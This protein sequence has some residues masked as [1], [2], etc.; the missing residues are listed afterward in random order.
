MYRANYPAS[1]IGL[2]VAYTS[3]EEPLLILTTEII[4]DWDTIQE[5]QPFTSE[6]FFTVDDV[7]SSTLNMATYSYE[8]TVV[9]AEM[10]T[11]MG[12][13]QVIGMAM[14]TV[15]PEDGVGYSSFVILEDPESFPDPPEA[16]EQVDDP[17]SIELPIGLDNEAI[18]IGDWIEDTLGI[19]LPCSDPEPLCVIAATQAYHAARAQE[20]EAWQNRIALAKLGWLA[21]KGAYHT[22][23]LALR[24]GPRI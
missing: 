14:T 22:A 3:D 8:A 24:G 15:N 20:L 17:D 18:S 5:S 19:V 12:T 23:K 10:S 4:A 13:H 11:D 16:S 21:A 9:R 2:T 6:S 7:N 1:E